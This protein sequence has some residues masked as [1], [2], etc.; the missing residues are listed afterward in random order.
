MSREIIQS[1]ITLDNGLGIIYAFLAMK[2]IKNIADRLSDYL[3]RQD[4]TLAQAATI[5]GVHF[6]TLSNIIL[7]RHRPNRRTAYK[8][9]ML[10][11]RDIRDARRILARARR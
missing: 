1:K 2:E 3:C 5:T 8:I 6:T 7:G 10:I 11:S 9:E 4:M